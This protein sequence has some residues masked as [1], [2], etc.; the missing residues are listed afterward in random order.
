MIKELKNFI[1]NS[2]KMG[3]CKEIMIYC[4]NNFYEIKNFEV[5][6]EMLVLNVGEVN[7]PE[8]RFPEFDNTTDDGPM[9]A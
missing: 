3:Q 2:D 5:F 6:E 9:V 4:G 7:N 1:N 8:I